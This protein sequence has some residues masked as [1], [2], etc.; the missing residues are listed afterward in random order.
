[1]NSVDIDSPIRLDRTFWIIYVL[2]G[3]PCLFF[4]R[5]FFA[6][7]PLTTRV[8]GI[9]LLPFLIA[10]VIY[11]FALF[12]AAVFFGGPIQRRKFFAFVITMGIVSIMFGIE[13]AVS[14]FKDSRWSTPAIGSFVAIMLYGALSRKSSNQSTD[15]TP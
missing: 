5:P 10:V 13:W 14:G 3:L 7:D 12:V 9:I 1:V 2:V 8:A 11:T 4:I 15:P 6:D